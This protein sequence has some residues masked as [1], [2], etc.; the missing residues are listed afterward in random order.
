[1]IARS[2]RV[3]A[4]MDGPGANEHALGLDAL[5]NCLRNIAHQ[6]FLDLESVSQRLNKFN[7]PA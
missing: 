2:A 6:E 4:K 5:F 1:M 3:D 7:D